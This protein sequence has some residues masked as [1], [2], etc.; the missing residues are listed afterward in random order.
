VAARYLTQITAW[1][2]ELSEIEQ[3]VIDQVSDHD[4]FDDDDDA[5]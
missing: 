1:G 4:E 3:S 5:G 2:Y